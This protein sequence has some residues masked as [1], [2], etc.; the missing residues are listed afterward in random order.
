MNILITG[1]T[2]FIGSHLIKSLL[3][4]KHRIIL[5]KRSFSNTDRIKRE[6]K[7]VKI[8]DIDKKNQMHSAF[9]DQK[10]DMIIHLAAHYVKYEKTIEDNEA[11][12]Q[13][14]LLFPLKLLELAKINH[15][16]YFINTGTCFEYQRKTT[17]ISE[18][19]LIEPYNY[20]AVTKV[21]FEESLKYYCAR[22]G[23]KAVTLKLF[24]PYG[25]QDNMKLVTYV[26][27]SLKDGSDLDLSLSEQ[28]LDYVY[29]K[30]V[31]DAYTKTIHFIRSKK[32]KNYISFNIGQGVGI[33]I[34]DFVQTAGNIAQSHVKIN[35]N[36][37]YHENEI[38]HMV[39]N[40]RQAQN[41][42]GWVAKTTV[43]E[44]LSKMLKIKHKQK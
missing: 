12:I 14:N 21:M 17:K 25:E 11:M 29:I 2:G 44:G 16:N 18:G 15:V 30:D 28:K 38:M 10:V 7:K 9:Q 8:Y 22:Y 32:Y 36:Q 6:I 41:I 3:K 19:D 37:P 31:I 35:F 13:S 20:Y 5:L 23:L 39:S 26:I 24:Y 43:E 4:K 33:R 42:L 27:K 40:N 1:G 34:K